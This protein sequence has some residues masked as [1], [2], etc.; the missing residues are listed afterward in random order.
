[1]WDKAGTETEHDY[2]FFSRKEDKD[3]QL[4]KGFWVLIMSLVA[5]VECVSD[6]M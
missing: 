5:R 1:M 6:R 4:G 3:R 2:V